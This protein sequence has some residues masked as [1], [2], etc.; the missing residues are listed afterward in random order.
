MKLI[1]FWKVSYPIRFQCDFI[2]SRFFSVWHLMLFLRVIMDGFGRSLV[3]FKTGYWSF[4]KYYGLILLKYKYCRIHP[5]LLFFRDLALNFEFA[6]AWKIERNKTA[7]HKCLQIAA[8]CS[9]TKHYNHTLG[10]YFSLP[11]FETG[12]ILTFR[13]CKNTVRPNGKTIQYRC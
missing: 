3:L 9:K 5:V 1:S 10:K 13:K 4:P 12:F 2:L 11:Y 6:N 8:K 7:C